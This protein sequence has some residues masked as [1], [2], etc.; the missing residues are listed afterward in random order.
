MPLPLINL[1]TRTFNDLVDEGHSIIPASAPSW[2]DF[3]WSDPGITLIDLLAWLTEQD[4]YRL[5]RTTDES[6]RSFLRLVGVRPLPARVAGTIL[7]LSLPSP[8]PVASAILP[9]GIQIGNSDTS[10]IFQTAEALNVSPAI[11][12]AILTGSDPGLVDHSTDN[13]PY[14]ALGTNP[15]PGSALYLGFDQP[16]ADPPME[17][18]LYVWV[19]DSIADA[20]TRARLIELSQAAKHE[21][22]EFCPRD[23]MSDL[24]DWR[25]HYSART[26]WEFYGSPGVWLPISGV[27]DETRA[28]TLSG[29][30]RFMAPPKNQQLQGGPSGA[31]YSPFYF[32]R[33]RLASGAHECPPL[34][35]AI[36]PNAVSAHHAADI[37]APESLPNSNGHAQQTF[38]LL[39]KPVVPCS[40]QVTVTIAPGVVETWREEIVWDQVGPHSNVYVLSPE[41]GQITFGDGRVGRVPP[42]A[43]AIT[44]NYQVGGGEAGSVSA[45]TLTTPLANSHNSTLVPTWNVLQSML[46][47]CQPYAAFGGAD[48]ETLADA[49]ARA[50]TSL[51]QPRRGVTLADFD[52]LALS[53]PA[54][55][56]ARAYAI[57][58]YH[59]DFP[60][61]PV[62]GSVT[63][64]VLPHCP[65]AQPKPTPGFLCA[66][67]R[68]ID[69]SR[70]IT[71]EVHVIGPTYTLVSISARLHVQP[72]VNAQSLTQLAQA[73]LTAFLNPLHGG[74][75]KTGW[76]AGR[77]VYRTEILAM[78][79]ALPGVVFVDELT[80]QADQ[81]PAISCDNLRICPHG[82]VA[83]GQHHI[84]ISVW[85]GNR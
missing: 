67:Q 50:F 61:F 52:S 38:Q 29:P 82:F 78:L 47:V 64:V 19:G 70:T 16:L 2:T 71:T 85:R 9:A 75:D 5:D 66:V 14:P 60:C 54:V 28:L 46:R 33:C 17:L 48:A 6:Y 73:A 62:S 8:S 35:N 22:D 12:K 45:K 63:V 20:Q 53:T 84:T 32:I 40:S 4:I 34:I 77:G 31:Q 65:D 11:L 69:R 13:Q 43:A 10:F 51:S 37:D 59:P 21:A 36:A 30:V 56:V 7:T 74:P 41:A 39:H 25:L 57:A 24:P 26:V 81:G 15:A 68:Y 27:V 1:D 83:S 44:V 80:L 79:N 72:G 76:P 58:N 18:R 42:D 23:V 55:P 3:N 49:M